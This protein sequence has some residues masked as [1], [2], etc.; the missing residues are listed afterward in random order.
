MG[1]HFLWS[2]NAWGVYEF[3][4]PVRLNDWMMIGVANIHGQQ[5]SNFR[6]SEFGLWVSYATWAR[7]NFSVSRCIF[8]ETHE[9]PQWLI[10]WDFIFS[11]PNLHYTMSGFTSNHSVQGSI[12][13]IQTALIKQ[14]SYAH[15]VKKER[16]KVYKEDKHPC[17]FL[18]NIF[19]V[20]FSTSCCSIHLQLFGLGHFACILVNISL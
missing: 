19:T 4:F 18:Q 14:G 10:K 5:T 20:I 8:I 6:G 17:V 13:T 2:A 11:A 16:N 1:R 12:P 7:L 15:Q 3:C 9:R